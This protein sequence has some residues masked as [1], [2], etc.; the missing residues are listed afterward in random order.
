MTFYTFSS[1]ALSVASL[2]LLG[3]CAVRKTKK[4]M[5]HTPE[6]ARLGLLTNEDDSGNMLTL[7]GILTLVQSVEARLPASS[8][9]L[10]MHPLSF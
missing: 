2:R 1:C 8:L 3:V 7:W 10:A 5:L 9:H 4:V 6:Q